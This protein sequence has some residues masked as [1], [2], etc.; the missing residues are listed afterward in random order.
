MAEV[1]VENATLATILMTSATV[2]T[3][4]NRLTAYLNNL[5]CYTI[6]L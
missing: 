4:S 1:I 2:D 5:C 6:L 3:H